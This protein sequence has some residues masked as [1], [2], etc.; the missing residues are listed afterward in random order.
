MES[1][2]GLLPIDV[3]YLAGL[4]NDIHNSTF[5]TAN[6]AGPSWFWKTIPRRQNF[7]LTFRVNLLSVLFFAFNANSSVGVSEMVAPLIAQ[8]LVF[9]YFELLG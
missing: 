3:R 5:S 7:S 4:V 2:A 8:T 9:F 1:F 6:T